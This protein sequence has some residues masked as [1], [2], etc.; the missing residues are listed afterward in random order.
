[1]QNGLSISYHFCDGNMT[2]QSRARESYPVINEDEC[3]GCGRCIAACPQK[4]LRSSGR[5]NR[6]GFIVAEYSG[7]GCTGCGFCFYN[8]PEPYAVEV[9]TDEE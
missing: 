1:M 9:H 7:E 3:K 4:A 8:C 5:G 6:N 2:S